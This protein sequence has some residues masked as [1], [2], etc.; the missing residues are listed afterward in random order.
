MKTISQISRQ[1]SVD[2]AKVMAVIDRAVSN[3]CRTIYEEKVVIKPFHDAVEVDTI[4]VD[5]WGNTLEDVTIALDAEALPPHL[6]NLVRTKVDEVLE[7][8]PN[9]NNTV[10]LEYEPELRYWNAQGVIQ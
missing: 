3:N 2:P 9:D 1:F 8:E 7:A 6:E 10:K 5:F 4:N